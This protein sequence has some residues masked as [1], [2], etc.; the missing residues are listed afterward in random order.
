[1]ILRGAWREI[2]CQAVEKVARRGLETW[3]QLGIVAA[4]L[5]RCRGEHRQDWR[6]AE[7]WG[8]VPP[9]FKRH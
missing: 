9:G 8:C 3:P 4:E 2:E 1:M 6:G 7:G 5:A